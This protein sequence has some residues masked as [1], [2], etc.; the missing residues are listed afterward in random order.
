MGDA[1]KMKKGVTGIVLSF[2]VL[3]GV[4]FFSM[5]CCLTESE[6]TRLALDNESAAA[7]VT[8]EA[9]SLSGRAS[10][11]DRSGSML[12]VDAVS[13]GGNRMFRS[14]PYGSLAAHVL[15]FNTPWGRGV[16][17]VE[18][19][20]ESAIK[21]MGEKSVF[22]L[23]ISRELQQRTERDL[24][25]Q[26]DRLEAESGCTVIMN[27]KNGQILAMAA[28]PVWNPASAWRDT[29]SEFANP[30]LEDNVDPWIILP[31]VMQEDDRE[32]ALTA[33]KKVNHHDSCGDHKKKKWR[34]S[35]IGE[36]LSIWN[37]WNE[38]LF[39]DAGLA[40]DAAFRLSKLGFGQLTGID[41]P[42]EK[43]G[44]IPARFPETLDMA[45]NAGFR[46]TPVQLLQAFALVL[47]RGKQI[48]PHV[49]LSGEHFVAGIHKKEK[50]RKGEQYAE[51][52]DSV[53]LEDGA[54]PLER[55]DYDAASVNL[56]QSLPGTG[57]GPALA[58]IRIFKDSG[59]KFLAQVTG[60]GFWPLDDPEICYVTVLNNVRRDPRIRRG[61]LG[62]TIK[63][64]KDAR[65]IA[66]RTEYVAAISKAGGVRPEYES[67]AGGA[68]V[69]VMPD[70]RG[71]PMRDAAERLFRLGV[72]VAASGSGRVV[73]Q[74]PRAG[75]D[76]GSVSVCRLICS[77][78][79]F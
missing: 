55:P 21:G 75:T 13:P 30:V 12:A 22:Y 71:L 29:V 15:G 57:S 8:S 77:N 4:S 32:P 52:V 35:D 50:D 67:S 46:A 54:L 70:F 73:R 74:E 64:A 20:Y 61:T 34:W 78:S 28:A 37:S 79:V 23:T 51:P 3:A 1:H 26:I 9:S 38:G 56:R 39:N 18:F 58:G 62:K 40:K 10:I 53:G 14:Y 60:M 47:N 44:M 2:L 63:I 27:V 45:G 48:V 76:L 43:Q 69:G 42:G 19:V 66:G 59:R 68:A 24:A 11:A 31:L 6:G 33:G 16:E 41:L 49:A 17:G 25:W 36:N 7:G 5:T 65:R 72:R